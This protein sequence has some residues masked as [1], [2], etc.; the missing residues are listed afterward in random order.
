LDHSNDLHCV[1]GFG[2]FFHGNHLFKDIDILFVGISNDN[3]KLYK[4]LKKRIS[5]LSAKF[6]ISF[7]FNFLTKQE[8]SENLYL[9]IIN[10]THTM[11][12]TNESD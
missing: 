10:N 3:F 12:Y 2:S 9:D 7:D 8:F 1:I 6:G 11:I 5:K 4:T